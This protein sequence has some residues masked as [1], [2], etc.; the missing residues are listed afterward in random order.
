[1]HPLLRVRRRS[2]LRVN[3]PSSGFADETSFS[4]PAVVREAASSSMEKEIPPLDRPTS[5]LDVLS[6]PNQVVTP[7]VVSLLPSLFSSNRRA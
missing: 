5:P 6:S 7:S 3:R 2:S 4:A 1:M